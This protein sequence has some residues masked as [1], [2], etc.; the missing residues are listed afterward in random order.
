MFQAAELERQ[1]AEEVCVAFVG[2]LFLAEL[3]F[4][5]WEHLGKNMERFNSRFK[6]RKKNLT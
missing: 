5:K 6:N 3:T 1:K 4:P 2:F